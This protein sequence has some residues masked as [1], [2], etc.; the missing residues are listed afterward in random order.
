MKVALIA[1]EAIC[2]LAALEIVASPQMREGIVMRILKTRREILGGLLGTL[3]APV[4]CPAA[5]RP[6]ARKIGGRVSLPSTNRAP[7][8]RWK[9]EQGLQ[10]GMNCLQ[11]FGFGYPFVNGSGDD[12]T[13][14]PDSRL[15]KIR[16]T[17]FD[18]VRMVVDP[19][20]LLAADS[21]SNVE[22]TELDSR[23]AEVIFGVGR[24]VAANMKVIV[25]LH[26]HGELVSYLPGWNYVDVFDG[27]TK[28]ARL[29]FV[30]TRLG[31]SIHTAA[32]MVCPPD[33]VCFEIFNEPPGPALVSTASYIKHIESWW[34]QVRA[35]MPQHTIIVGG[36]NSNAIDGRLAGTT[37]GLISL[38]AS[39]FDQNTG[40][41][42]HCYTSPVFT[43]QA[44][45]GTIFQYAHNIKFPASDN[46]SEG[47]IKK[48]FVIAARDDS[49]AIKA[50]V[51]KNSQYS[52]IHQ[53]F[54]IYGTKTA[55]AAYLAVATAWADRAGIS[56]KR[57]FNTEFGVNF[58][59]TEDADDSSV[60]N[61]LRATRE[62]SE[63]AGLNCITLHEMQGSNFGIQNSSAPW[64]FN[65][66]ILGA[67]FP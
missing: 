36:N 6:G 14:M 41:A 50:V 32:R 54:T 55:L 31:A 25:D 26:F 27:G 28:A 12:A 59:G 23:I 20:P 35:V 9:S 3:A 67:L 34:T 38:T 51:T 53:F 18:F 39:H 65:S 60:A 49:E 56:H 62:I 33:M 45:T 11:P 24:R 57:I 1:V 22:T 30:L 48:A 16:E 29:G 43:L 19:E 61:F 37:S 58:A 47:A 15:N 42:I 17:G 2:E 44:V 5:S 10:I 8:L 64:E 63:D 40:F 13:I 4:S 46:A 7:A 21:A 52:S 66:S